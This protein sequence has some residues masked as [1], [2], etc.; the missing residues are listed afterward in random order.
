MHV[1]GRDD[2]CGAGLAHDLD[3]LPCVIEVEGL[4]I[5]GFRAADWLRQHRD[6]DVHL[7]D[8]RRI[9]TQVTHADDEGTVGELLGALEDLAQAASGLRPVPPVEV[10]DPAE[11]RLEQACAPR[12]AFFG[13]V[14][15]VPTDRAA[16]RVA[17]EMI[18]PYPPGIPVVLPGERLTEPV[19]RYLLTG[20]D[21]GMN[22]PDPSDPGLG[23]VRVVRESAE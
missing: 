5:S 23:T 4:G 3:P 19:L 7:S 10:P 12:D 14:E 17:A 11:L 8:H 20:R 6:I 21:A 13:P 18:T 9:G 22:L 2:L 15:E 1:D 16:G